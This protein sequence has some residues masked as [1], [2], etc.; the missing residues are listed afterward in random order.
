MCACSQ[1]I[2]EGK[3]PGSCSPL[4]VNISMFCLK[5]FLGQGW[6]MCSPT[7]WLTSPAQASHWRK[8]SGHSPCRTADNPLGRVL[9]QGVKRLKPKSPWAEL[10]TSLLDLMDHKSMLEEEGHGSTEVRRAEGSST[11]CHCSVGKTWHG[12]PVP[13]KR[14]SKCGKQV[15]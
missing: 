4:P 7:M 2:T 1:S 14:Q 15:K 10:N 13:R 12:C 9:N 6:Q 11:I 5:C 3:K 8:D